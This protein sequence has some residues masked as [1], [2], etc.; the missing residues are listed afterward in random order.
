MQELLETEVVGRSL[1]VLLTASIILAGGVL[2]TL[3]IRKVALTVIKR[4]DRRRAAEEGGP[5]R[6]EGSEGEA[7]PEQ[8]VGP[9]Q[10]RTD[11]F[12]ARTVRS[13]VTPVLILA[14]FY[15]AVAVIGLSGRA[16]TATNAVLVV[17][18]SFVVIRFLVAL[19]NQLFNRFITIG[20]GAD[21]TRIRPLRSVAIVVVWLIGLLF[22]LDNL[23]FNVSAVVAG[24]GIGGI[25][26][27]LAAQELLG[28]L[29]AYFVILFD[30][31]FELG[32]FLIFGDIL[33]SVEHIGVKTTRLRSLSGEQIIVSNGDLTNSR[34]RNYKRMEERR[35]VFRVGVVYSTAI[36][37]LETIPTMI[38]EIVES[39]ELARFDRAHFAAYGD[40]SLSFEVVFYVLSPDYAV[41]MDIQERINLG[42][43]RRFQEQEIEFAF[44][45]RTIELNRRPESDV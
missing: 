11:S 17:L 7:G 29:F 39:E 12:A 31:P 25:A 41:Y 3:L 27:A 36:E 19:L 24:L 6:D 18:F 10:G 42:I 44:P 40:W 15:G 30:R 32:D 21:I 8:E 1:S 5:A 37:K 38:R 45:T 33:G 34:V 9:V 43:Y 14:S 16:A 35:V 2:L 26:V 28:D 13:F 4:R 20:S 23:G 22:L